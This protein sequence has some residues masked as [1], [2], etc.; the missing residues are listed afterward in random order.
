MDKAMTVLKTITNAGRIITVSK[1]GAVTTDR[2]ANVLTVSNATSVRSIMAIIVREEE[3]T[4]PHTTIKAVTVR[5]DRRMVK[6]VKA[7][8]TKEAA[9]SETEDTSSNKAA[10]DN[11]AMTVRTIVLSVLTKDLPKL[12]PPHLRAMELPEATI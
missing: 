3:A 2:M 11:T 6:V 10:T 9:I 12:I 4:V 8:T 1:T 5:E 7:A